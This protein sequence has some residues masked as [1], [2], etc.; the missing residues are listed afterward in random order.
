MLNSCAY[1]FSKQA[2]SWILLFSLEQEGDSVDHFETQH[3][4]QSLNFSDRD[5]DDE[6]EE[7]AAATLNPA[8]AQ[9]IQTWINRTEV[10]EVKSS[11]IA[12]VTGDF[13]FEIEDDDDLTEA[14][15]DKG[16]DY[17][18]PVSQRLIFFRLSRRPQ[19]CSG[20]RAPTSRRKTVLDRLLC[21][22]CR[23]LVFKDDRWAERTRSDPAG[24]RCRRERAA[25]P[26]KS[27]ALHTSIFHGLLDMVQMLWKWRANPYLTN[28]KGRDAFAICADTLGQEKLTQ[29]T[30]EQ[31]TI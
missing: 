11:G 3:E 29:E 25:C 19:A 6:F 30:T 10:I 7:V 15:V 1:R 27:P 9:S 28:D 21:S 26:S 4:V 5:R 23:Q 2:T 16:E 17:S 24:S 8:K 13:Q 20:R 14:P 31:V 22:R 18:R 12:E